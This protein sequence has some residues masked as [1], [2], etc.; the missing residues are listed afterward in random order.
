MISIT[1]CP[2]GHFCPIGSDAPQRCANGTFQDEETQALCDPCPEGYF[3]D[4]TLDIVILDNTTT[5][6]PVGHY[7]PVGTSFSNQF[8]CPVGT[9]NNLTGMFYTI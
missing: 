5:V 8:P 9:F 3:C 1:S 6:C 7:C 4:N 2:V